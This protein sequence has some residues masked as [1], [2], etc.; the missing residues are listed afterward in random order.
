M[1]SAT[2]SPEH[3]TDGPPD[4]TDPDDQDLAA[5]EAFGQSIRPAPFLLSMSGLWEIFSEGKH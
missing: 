5:L 1:H 4:S 3:A 2:D